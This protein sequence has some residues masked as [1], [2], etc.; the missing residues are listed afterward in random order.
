M[1]PVTRAPAG[2]LVAMVLTL[3]AASARRAAGQVSP[4]PLALP[5]AFLEGVRNCTQCHGT[6][7]EEMGRHC[8]ACH[9]DIK[10]LTDRG[11]G[12]HATVTNQRCAACHPDHAGRDL[13]LIA[14]PGGDS[15][16]FD[17]RQTGW[18]LEG[19]HGKVACGTC[20]RPGLRVSAAAP[21]SQR[22]TPGG[23]T[24]LEPECAACHA[25]PH[26]GTLAGPC[27]DCHELTGW[28]PAPGFVHDSTRYP[29]T[30]RHR[31]VACVKCHVSA[32][33][34]A[35]RAGAAAIPAVFSPVPHA[36]C[37]NCHR[38][39]HGGRLGTA[40]ARCHTTAGF[41]TFTT[42]TF[43]HEH[44]RYPLRGAHQS[45]RCDLCHDFRPGAALRD[46]PFAT[47]AGCHSPDPHAGTATVAGKV[48]DCAACHTVAGFTPATYTVAQHATTRFALLGRHQ[49]VPCA[50]CH[51]RET[52]PAARRALGA[53]GV[54]LRPPLQC[55]GCHEDP[56]EG[57]EN[58]LGD[59]VTCHLETGFR[60]STVDAT[61]HGRY[62]FAL[63]GA[64]RAV[65]C[66]G[67]HKDLARPGVR[68][69]L[70]AAGTA[71][72]DCH[73]DPH[74]GQFADTAGARPARACTDCHGT[75]AF[76]P[77]RFDHDRDAGFSLTG[78][79][80]AVPCA[81]CHRSA[82]VAGGRTVTRYRGTPRACEACHTS[83]ARR[84]S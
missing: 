72:R 27:T 63:T 47:C 38:D 51:V 52:N 53:A 32:P 24:G 77:A 25:D 50:G 19:A 20:H 55:T 65:P 10:W 6:R 2:L 43:D 81:R 28:R 68:P 74:G 83:P 60:P 33:A 48:V 59:C 4:G 15:T 14:W 30:G 13:A 64:H 82:P 39:P 36:E 84:G 79:H 71:C 80:A 57:H 1:V 41:T 70:F 66:A 23:W 35:A 34:G 37:A 76:R 54:R 12:F 73:T 18:P 8:L 29:L 44:T 31:D 17:H 26:R 40:C 11:R 49:T 56:H 46:R 78:G 45:V 62:R 16:R 42:G 67:C 69:L 22:K 5:H 58:A 21:L 9:R 61:A 7:K 3:T 75:D